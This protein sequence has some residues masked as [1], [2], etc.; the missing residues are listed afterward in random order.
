[1]SFAS[2]PNV[3]LSPSGSGLSANVSLETYLYGGAAAAPATTPVVPGTDTTSTAT[4]STNTTSTGASARTTFAATVRPP[5][6][7]TEF[8]LPSSGSVV[9]GL[10]KGPDG[11]VWFTETRNYIGRISPTGTVT[12]KDGATPLG[13]APVDPA[14][15]TATI[16]LGAGLGFAGLRSATGHENSECEM[17]N[18]E[19]R[20]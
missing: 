10:A 16:T 1:M 12:F 14:T 18:A 15:H 2:S 8:P 7:V 6:A 13:S 19:L 17:R 5:A 3:T 9:F 4:T 20:W 11:A